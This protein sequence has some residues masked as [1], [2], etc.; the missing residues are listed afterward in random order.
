MNRKSRSL[1]CAML[2]ALCGSAQAQQTMKVL[3]LIPRVPPY[4]TARQRGISS[5][6]SNFVR[7]V[8]TSSFIGNPPTENSIAFPHS[9]QKWCVT[10]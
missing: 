5:Q 3:R 2:L 10:N 8:K 1:L 6:D 4:N 7:R 9:R